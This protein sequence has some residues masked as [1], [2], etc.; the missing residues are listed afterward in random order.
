MAYNTGKGMVFKVQAG[1]YIYTFVYMYIYFFKV[2][3]NHL[4]NIY[5]HMRPGLWIRNSF[6]PDPDPDPG[7]HANSDP[8]PDPIRIQ[9][10][11]V[12]KNFLNKIL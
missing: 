4:A 8:D 10:K 5:V 6:N 11:V 12:T 7:N 9:V 3:Y 1:I 2:I